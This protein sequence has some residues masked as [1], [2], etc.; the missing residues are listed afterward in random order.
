MMNCESCGEIVRYVTEMCDPEAPD[1]FLLCDECRDE[2]SNE[3]IPCAVPEGE[4]PRKDTGV[5]YD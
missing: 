1:Q 3:L 2:Y 5:Y 4:N